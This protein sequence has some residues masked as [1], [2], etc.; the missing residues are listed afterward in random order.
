M[1][2]KPKDLKASSS[3]CSSI[4][5]EPSASYRLNASRASC[6]CSAVSR[7]FARFAF[8]ILSESFVRPPPSNGGFSEVRK[9][10]AA[11]VSEGVSVGAPTGGSSSMGI[12]KDVGKYTQVHDHPVALMHYAALSPFCVPGRYP[13]RLLD[14]P[15]CCP[16]PCRAP[17][18]TL[19]LSPL[20]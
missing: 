2:S 3:S 6:C 11:L 18:S 17:P 7:T 10:L 13:M 1:V 4:S 9:I 14:A 16:S 20:L 12:P 19:P 15:A 8:G 5:P